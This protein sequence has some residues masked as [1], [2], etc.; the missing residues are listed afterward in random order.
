MC[1]YEMEIQPRDVLFFR[2]AKPMEASSVG[3]GAHWPWPNSLHDSLMSAF[4]HKWPKRQEWEFEHKNKN[5]K[6]R[7]WETS[8][9]RFGGLKTVGVFPVQNG[10]LCFPKPADI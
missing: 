4:H 1:W 10:E 2:D 5:G 7:N 3:E 6:D 9:M 8:S